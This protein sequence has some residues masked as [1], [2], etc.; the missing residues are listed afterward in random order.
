MR[1]IQCTRVRYID[2]EIV[3][4]KSNNIIVGS[5]GASQAIL[6]AE[7]LGKAILAHVSDPDSHQTRYDI[8]AAL[9][10]YQDER[11][12]PTARIVM[13]NRGNGPDQVMEVAEQRAPDGFKNVLDVIPKEELEDIGRAY[14]AIAGFEM[15]KV[16]Q[17]ADETEGLA[18]KL[19]LRGPQK[20]SQTAI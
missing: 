11:L 9:K 1:R 15:D 18:E 13:A 20:R 2:I 7:A 8:P 17:K 5:N 10:A 4:K 19:G 6:D 16:N 12:T 3:Y 14:K